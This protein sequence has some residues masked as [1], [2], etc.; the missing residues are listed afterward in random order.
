M[1]DICLIIFFEDEPSK[2]MV[3]VS[4]AI[5]WVVSPLENPSNS[6]SSAAGRLRQTQQ[7]VPKPNS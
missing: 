7:V 3:A 4:L 1:L 6:K 5:G 2:E